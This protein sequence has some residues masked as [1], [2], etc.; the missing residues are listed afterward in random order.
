MAQISSL[1]LFEIDTQKIIRIQKQTLYFWRRLE[2][3]ALSFAPPFC[4]FFFDSE[5]FTDIPKYF[6]IRV[7]RRKSSF[8]VFFG[9]LK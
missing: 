3:L 9:K 4:F 7:F 1:K 5:A 2:Y 8:P 6:E